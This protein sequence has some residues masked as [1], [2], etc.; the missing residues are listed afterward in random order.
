MERAAR[1]IDPATLRGLLIRLAH[2]DGLA[3]GIGQ[4]NVWEELA[5]AALT[6][7]GRALAVPHPQP[8]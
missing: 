1:R 4:G 8:V 3:K 2:L 7:C 5:D 6:L